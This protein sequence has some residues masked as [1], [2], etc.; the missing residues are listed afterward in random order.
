M[1]CTVV[2]VAAATARPL[3]AHSRQRQQLHLIMSVS[4]SVCVFNYVHARALTLALMRTLPLELTLT[5]HT[6]HV[7]PLTSLEW[8][9]RDQHTSHLTP[10]T[11]LHTAI[12]T[13]YT[14]PIIARHVLGSRWSAP[15]LKRGKRG[16]QNT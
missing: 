4:M 16:R 6:S 10:H 5:P 13:P 11:S 2:H 7:K 12:L 14:L 1:W 8:H 9:V 3:C 15:G